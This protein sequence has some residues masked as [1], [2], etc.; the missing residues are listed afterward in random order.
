MTRK[1]DKLVAVNVSVQTRSTNAL[2]TLYIS[3]VVE[4][5]TLVDLRTVLLKDG[6]VLPNDGSVFKLPEGK[7]IGKSSEG[8]VKWCTL[9]QVCVETTYNLIP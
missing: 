5:G 3:H 4:D 2:K 8:H 1:S 9:L 6:I 7:L